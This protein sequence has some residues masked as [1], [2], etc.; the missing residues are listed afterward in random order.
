ML[1]G[2]SRA[3]VDSDVLALI[4]S[5]VSGFHKDQLGT[6]GDVVGSYSTPW[7]AKATM[8][9]G[10]SA[11]TFTWSNTP[12]TSTMTTTT[13]KTGANGEKVGSVTWVAG[14]T[15]ITVPVILKG[16]I[17]GPSNWWR[18]THPALLGK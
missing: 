18:L 5:L 9:L 4:T 1:A 2:E 15:R 6:E 13:L 7:G 10:K 3:S 17:K 12:I 8:V 16:K 11:S 14:K